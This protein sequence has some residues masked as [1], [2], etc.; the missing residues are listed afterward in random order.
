MVV[1]ALLEDVAR[2]GNLYALRISLHRKGQ[3]DG[4][5]QNVLKGIGQWMKINV[6]KQPAW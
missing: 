1:H 5:R 2:D 3:W 4:K 6:G